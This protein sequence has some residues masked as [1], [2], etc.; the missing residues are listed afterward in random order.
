MVIGIIVGATDL[1]DLSV[2]L[3]DP[4]NGGLQFDVF[5][6]FAMTFTM[7]HIFAVFARS[8]LNPEIRKLYPI[9]FFVVPAVL[10]IVWNLSMVAWI[11]GLIFLVWMDNYHS[12]LQTF[13]LGRLYD[14][15]QGNDP[16]AGRRLDYFMALLIYAGPILAGTT[17]AS[18]LVDFEKFE[19]VGLMDLARFPGWAVAHQY[20]YLTLP[21]LIGGG[22]FLI[23]YIYAYWRLV[24]RGYQ[25][26]TQK[27]LLYVALGATSLY[28]WGFDSFGQS[29]LIM[30]SFHS[31]Q[32]FGIVWWAEREGMQRSLRLTSVRGGKWLTLAV[33]LGVCAAFGLWV[34]LFSSTHFELVL[35]GTIELM[36]YWW[37]GFIWSV[38]KKQVR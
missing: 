34:S 17:F 16:V 38:R 10:L 29:F 15:R 35:F 3:G 13:G 19:S 23:Y 32:Y 27:V 25:V 21:I 9:R 1:A 28:T 5:P 26:S 18:T 8:Y 22:L 36:H 14:M 20:Q 12:S 33:F 37:D 11:C 31:L 2:T 24:Q 7:A 6:T 4:E 30:E